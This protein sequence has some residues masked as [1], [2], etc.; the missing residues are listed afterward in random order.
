MS[1]LDFLLEFLKKKYNIP[2]IAEAVVYQRFR[3]C[4][5][6]CFVGII[7]LVRKIRNN[8]NKNSHF[9]PIVRY[10]E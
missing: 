2:L 3:F 10:H 8:S 4:F 7:A 6:V 1:L 9:H 5:Y